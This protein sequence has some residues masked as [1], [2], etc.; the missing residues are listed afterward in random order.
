L[1]LVKVNDAKKIQNT[2]RWGKVY[3]TI[4][5]YEPTKQSGNTDI[6][7]LAT[8]DMYIKDAPFQIMVCDGS[9]PNVPTKQSSSIHRDI[10][11]VLFHME[12][13][14]LTPLSINKKT[15]NGAY[16][17]L[18]ITD[19]AATLT[20][21]NVPKETPYKFYMAPSDNTK[22]YE[23]IFISPM[24]YV[25]AIRHID[26]V[27]GMYAGKLTIFLDVEKGY[28]LSSTKATNGGKNDPTNV[29]LEV[30]SPED[31]SPNE[32]GIGSAY[33]KNTKTY[34][35]RSSQRIQASVDGPA[36]KETN[37][38]YIKLVRST[39]DERS[40]SNC[41]KCLPDNIEPLT[42]QLKER[43]LSQTYDNPLT[44]DRV[45]VTTRE[46][47][48]PTTVHFTGCNLDALTPNLQWTLVSNS[49]D[50]KPMEG[51]W[52]IRSMEAVLTKAVGTTESC[53]VEAMCIIVPSISTSQA[54]Q[55]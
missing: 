24:N 17:N 36:R 5:R 54:I 35:L 6:R 18:T 51:R 30:F 3:L 8:G 9:P 55:K 39:F 27:Y 40:G 26:K 14:P 43:V 38:E 49:E 7:E 12:L 23:S 32:I 10:P 37:G 21:A 31:T 19:L 48:A 53:N 20:A 13:A 33:D 42:G 34:R 28:L 44:A 45:R 15:N 41:R 2:W 25:P 11:S 29:N 16:H 47:Y 52:R 4:E 1:Q 22:K 46:N 50:M